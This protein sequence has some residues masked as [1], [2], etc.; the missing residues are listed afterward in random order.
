[1]NF[2]GSHIENC[3]IYTCSP[4]LLILKQLA[5]NVKVQIGSAIFEL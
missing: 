3:C 2:K 4:N 1:M 5:N